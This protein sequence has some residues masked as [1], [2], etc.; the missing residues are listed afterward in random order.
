LYQREQ[1]THA[2]MVYIDSRVFY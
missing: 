1:N 2:S